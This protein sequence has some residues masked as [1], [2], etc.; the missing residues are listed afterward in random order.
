MCYVSW[1]FSKSLTLRP[2]FEMILKLQLVYQHSNKQSSGATKI[3][4]TFM[5]MQ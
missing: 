2:S 4:H 5:K 3:Q 1:F